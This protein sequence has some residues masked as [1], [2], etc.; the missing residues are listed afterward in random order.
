MALPFSPTGFQE[1]SYC[2]CFLRYRRQNLEGFVC[3]GE[4]QYQASCIAP[5][6]IDLY[7]DK[8]TFYSIGSLEVIM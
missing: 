3:A 8:G 1:Q 2:A 5:K 4:A 6:L 7:L